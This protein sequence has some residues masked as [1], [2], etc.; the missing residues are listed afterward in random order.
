MI[1]Q[2]FKIIWNR[3]RAN[4]LMIT[5]IFCSFLVMF[6]VL[7]MLIYYGWNYKQPLGFQW[8]DV[9]V[10]SLNPKNE[11]DE[12]RREL[13]RQML[14]TVR[15]FPEVESATYCSSNYPF[16][17][18]TWITGVN[19]E[20]RE[21]DTFVFY[22][23]DHYGD[24]L[25]IPV[26]Q[27]R[28]Y[29]QSDDAATI[30]PVVINRA[31]KKALFGEEDCIGRTFTDGSTEKR[32]MRVVGLVD[33]YRYKGELADP[34]PAMFMRLS[35]DDPKEEAYSGLLVRVR[36]GTPVTFQETLV[37]SGLDILTGWSINV[38]TLKDMRTAY[39]KENLTPVIFWILIGGFLIL[40]VALGMFG[41]LWY[42]INRRTSE[43]GL[44]RAVGST[45]GR[46]SIQILGEILVLTT[47]GLVAG[48]ILAMQL[49][50]TGAFPTVPLIVY[51][52]GFLAASMAIYLITVICALYPSRLAS[53][54][55][56]AIALHDE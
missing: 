32:E 56:P 55:Q 37:K 3:K 26:T 1:R 49:P 53:R 29:D 35:L 25:R 48:G 28:W 23:D 33:N 4:G 41:V 21:A 11:P 42:N 17:R 16:S 19:L 30:Q 8:D 54:I 20:N 2:M 22:G 50:V 44:R 12:S 38:R 10:L 13:L 14:M 6:G 51:A 15:S 9:V 24:T 36:P 45:A 7:T 40:N 31:L 46:I 5:E 47:F 27:G 43:I 18:S 52:L 39:F 34:Y